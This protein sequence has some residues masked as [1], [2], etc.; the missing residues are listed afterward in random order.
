MHDGGQRLNMNGLDAHNDECG[1]VFTY[2]GWGENSDGK[3]CMQ[4]VMGA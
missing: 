4:V 3:V 1:F 2:G